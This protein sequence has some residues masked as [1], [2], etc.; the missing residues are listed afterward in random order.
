MCQPA[1]AYFSAGASYSIAITSGDW[2]A[3][4]TIVQRNQS[5]TV[6]GLPSEQAW[7]ACGSQ[8]TLQRVDQLTVLESNSATECIETTLHFE[9]LQLRAVSL[10]LRM[11][12]LDSIGESGLPRLYFFW[13]DQPITWLAHTNEDWQWFSFPIPED[14]VD[15][16]LRVSMLPTEQSAPL[17]TQ[18][19]LRSVQTSRVLLANADTISIQSDD[20]A[21]TVFATLSNP[22]TLFFSATGAVTLHTADLPASGKLRIWSVDTAGNTESP[23]TISF[24][25]P[26]PTVDA[27]EI[28]WQHV[29]QNQLA[30][31][32]APQSITNEET[33]L[34]YYQLVMNSNQGAMRTELHQPLF[35]NANSFYSPSSQVS[36]T[37]AAPSGSNAGRLQWVDLLGRAGPMSDLI[38]W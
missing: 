37:I 24:A 32:V 29:D 18:V 14:V 21:A 3:P 35:P 38:L 23:K 8:Q 15:G 36:L 31:V 16:R 25:Q 27:P 22:A 10:E 6:I 9:P 13:N 5:E 11:L 30:V 19:A 17:H 1:T 20:P 34:G 12:P 33:V 26:P 7:I 4:Q 2:V 28:I